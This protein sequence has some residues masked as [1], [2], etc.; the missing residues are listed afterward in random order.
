MSTGNA[1]LA[2]SKDT[3]L[4]FSIHVTTSGNDNNGEEEDKE[5]VVLERENKGFCWC[6]Y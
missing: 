5:M 1:S 3:H 2:I 4:V 6:C